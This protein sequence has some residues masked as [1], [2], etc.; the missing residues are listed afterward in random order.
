MMQQVQF[1]NVQ[2]KDLLSICSMSNINYILQNSRQLQINVDLLSLHA[3]RQV[4]KPMQKF[5]NVA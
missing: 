5:I 1:W 2:R 3:A 4:C